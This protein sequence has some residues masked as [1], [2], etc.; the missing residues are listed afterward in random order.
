M[1]MNVTFHLSFQLKNELTFKVVMHS[2]SAKLVWHTYIF[3]FTILEKEFGIQQKTGWVHPVSHRKPSYLSAL[4]STNTGIAWAENTAGEMQLSNYYYQNSWRPKT[5]PSS[6]GTTKDLY[7]IAL[8]QDWNARIIGSRFLKTNSLRI[9][10][11]TSYERTRKAGQE[12]K[13]K[14][15]KC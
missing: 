11:C 14:A 10:R 5:E 13:V 12:E 15:A 2:I 6:S 8:F 4:L 7:F 9:V 1:F 3:S